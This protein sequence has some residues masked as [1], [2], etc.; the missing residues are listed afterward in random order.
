MVFY[1]RFVA[2]RVFVSDM[3]NDYVKN[4]HLLFKDNRNIVE[5]QDPEALDST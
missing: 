5:R 3:F 4:P 1:K 2:R